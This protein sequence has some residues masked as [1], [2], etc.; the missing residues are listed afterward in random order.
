MSPSY[1]IL[2]DSAPHSLRALFP[3]TS[4][5]YRVPPPEPR[6]PPLSPADLRAAMLHAE[7]YLDAALDAQIEDDAAELLR[8][9]ETL[10]GLVAV[11]TG[12][13]RGSSSENLRTLQ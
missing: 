11:V 2:P 1:I 4:F 8:N 5:I 3:D 13:L 6:R 9:L 12:Q 10:H 7:T